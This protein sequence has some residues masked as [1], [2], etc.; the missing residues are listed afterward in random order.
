MKQDIDTK[1]ISRMNNIQNCD[2]YI[3]IPSSQTD[4]FYLHILIFSL[5]ESRIE[6]EISGLNDSRRNQMHSPLEFLL[7][8]MFYS[9]I[10]YLFIH[11]NCYFKHIYVMYN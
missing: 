5:P 6:D 2:I 8:I 7:I 9:L 4:K 1:Y 3:N 11:L 10:M